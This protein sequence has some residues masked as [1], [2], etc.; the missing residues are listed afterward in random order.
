MANR[1]ELEEHKKT[2]QVVHLKIML[3]NVGSF[4]TT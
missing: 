3:D 2:N 4:I 1:E